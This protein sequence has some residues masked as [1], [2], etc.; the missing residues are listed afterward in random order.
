M[1]W[2]HLNIEHF[3]HFNLLVGAGGLLLLLYLFMA[4]LV[5]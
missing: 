2:E 3:N 4:L 1:V 5:A